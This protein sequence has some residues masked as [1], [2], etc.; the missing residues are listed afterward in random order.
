LA[1]F[2]VAVAVSTAQVAT[3]RLEGVVQDPSGAV[4]PSAAVAVVN[5]RTG[6][7]AALA[8][9]PHGVFVFPSLPPGEYR[10][11]MEARG[12]RTAVVTGLALNVASTAKEV[13]QLEVGQAYETLT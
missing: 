7:R 13:V 4:V 8:T 9:D 2:L 5:E 11:T 6:K 12:F 1:S 3:S 10:M